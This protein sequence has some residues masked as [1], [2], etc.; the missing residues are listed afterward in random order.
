MDRRRFISAA[1][2]AT[3]IACTGA[4]SAAA[5][6]WP[7]ARAMVKRTQSLTLACPAPEST[8]GL[9]DDA[10]IL[11]RALER[12][13]EQRVKI[14]VVSGPQGSIDA[15]GGNGADLFYGPEH[16]NAAR[17]PALGFLAGLSGHLAMGARDLRAFVEQG[18]ANLWTMCLAP[19]GIIP[20]YAGHEGEAPLLWSRRR[21]DS[22]TGLRISTRGLNARAVSALGAIPIALPPDEIAAALAAGRVD[23]VEIADLTHAIALGLPAVARFAAHAA[24]AD[25]AGALSLS[26]DGPLWQSWSPKTRTSVLSCVKEQAKLREMRAAQSHDVLQSALGHAFDTEFYTC[27]GA[28]LTRR[29]GEALLAELAALNAQTR[30]IN[31]VYMAMWSGSA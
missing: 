19:Y 6:A 14:Q 23:A 2:A 29:V 15:I 20:I 13:F 24:L 8:A 21:I 26:V 7:A 3:A 17:I 30:Q 22:L 25:H 16:A 18:G 28:H 1:S 10:R 5:R 9:F 31:G 4:N 12:A 11:V 27:P